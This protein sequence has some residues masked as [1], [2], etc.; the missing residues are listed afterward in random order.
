MRAASL[1]IVD[2]GGGAALVTWKTTIPDPT[3]RPVF[4]PSCT[5]VNPPQGQSAAGDDRASFES[6]P[7]PATHERAFALHCAGGLM[8]PWLAVEGLGPVL[9]E[10]IVRVARPNGSVLSRVLT[11]SEPRWEL[12]SANAQLDVARQYLSLGVRHILGGADH[13]LFLLA[14]VLYVRRLRDVLWTETAFTL[15]HSI[16]FSATALGWIHVSAAA[17]EACIALSLVLVALEIGASA[18]P[19]SRARGQGPAI[20][21]VFG[22]VHGL[23]FAG[24]LGEIGIPDRE[25]AAALVAFG[26]GVEVGQ[27]AFLLVVFPVVAIAS[28]FGQ[29]PRLAVAGNYAVGVTGCCWLFQRLAVLEPERAIGAALSAVQLVPAALAATIGGLR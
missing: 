23:G 24:A 11:P 19:D 6:A 12:P 10:A 4:A 29:F 8:G 14:L 26:V 25:V 22:L 27:L 18:Q 21:L 5:V 15:S 16:S 13:L 9:T 2:S 3:V 28:R 20:A 17:A 1:E 7:L